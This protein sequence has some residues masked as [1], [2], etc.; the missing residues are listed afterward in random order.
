[1]EQPY[2]SSPGAVALSNVILTYQW[3]SINVG[4]EIMKQPSVGV[5]VVVQIQNTGALRNQRRPLNFG[6]VQ[7]E[8]SEISGLIIDNRNQTHHLARFQNAD[9]FQLLILKRWSVVT[10][11]IRRSSFSSLLPIT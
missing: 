8:N 7:Y 3:S 10:V 9:S 4:M 5:L 2:A 1:M 11:E 6:L